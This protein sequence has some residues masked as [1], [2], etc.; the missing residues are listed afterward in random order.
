LSRIKREDVQEF[1]KDQL[2]EYIQLLKSPQ[3]SPV[4]FMP[5][6]DKKKRMVQDY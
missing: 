1:V 5:K 6:K 4:L 3:T 2:K